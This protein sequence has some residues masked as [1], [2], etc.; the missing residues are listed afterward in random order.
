MNHREIIELWPS[1]RELASDL[2]K[3]YETVRKW[4]F[5]NNIPADYWM[6]IIDA[7]KKRRI[8]VTLE[9]LA[10]RCAA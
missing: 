2:G 4:R 1:A 6:P 3:N 10:A 5:R 7:G 9:S 8:R